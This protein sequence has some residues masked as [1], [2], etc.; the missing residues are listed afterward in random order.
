MPSPQSPIDDKQI[1]SPGELS[2]AV[3]VL[4]ADDHP[5]VREGLVALISRCPDMHVVAEASNGRSAVEKFLSHLPNVALLDLRMPVMSG[6]Q[7]AAAIC[8]KVPGA[9]VIIVTSYHT[10][11]DIYSAL[12]AGAQGYLLKDASRADFIESIR[13]VSDGGTWIPPVVGA[14]LAKRVTGQELTTREMEVMR[15]MSQGKSNKEIGVALNIC[16][17]TV[18]VHMTHILEKLKAAGRT[19]AINVAARRGLVHMDS[20]AA[21]SV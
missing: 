3:T 7:A 8:E 4:I 11:E 14:T 19:E 5:V 21:G 13:V 1:E 12:R 18:K 17:A 6:V 10:Q 2:G 9:R 15:T 16:E 20:P